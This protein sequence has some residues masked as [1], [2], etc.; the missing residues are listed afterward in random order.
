MDISI[1]TLTGKVIPLQVWSSMTIE[2]VKGMIQD[3]EGIHVDQQQL[4][5]SPNS[6]KD[7]FTLKTS[8]PSLTMSFMT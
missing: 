4:F 2:N 5:C 1:R 3:K 7:R 8:S 6:F